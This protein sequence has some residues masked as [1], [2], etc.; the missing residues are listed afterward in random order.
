[1]VRDAL[2]QGRAIS[3]QRRFGKALNV[4]SQNLGA[5]LGQANQ[6]ASRA[7]EGDLQGLVGK[8]RGNIVDMATQRECPH[9]TDLPKPSSLL[10][11]VV[12][13]LHI[14]QLLF[15][16]RRVGTARVPG[17][18]EGLQRR[19]STHC[20]ARVLV[21]EKEDAGLQAALECRQVGEDLLLQRLAGNG[22]V[23]PFNPGVLLRRPFVN[24]A[25][26]HPQSYQPEMEG[27]GK[28]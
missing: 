22:L 18:W 20:A 3:H 26:L 23:M 17:L 28:G 12:N 19:L 8:A 13:P 7:V 5:V 21:I 9:R 15:C 11:V 2:W 4:Q 24:K 16:L 25:H 10:Q 14:E 1:L 27:A 6:L